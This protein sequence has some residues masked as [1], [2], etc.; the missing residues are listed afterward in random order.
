MPIT[1]ILAIKMDI[2]IKI[3]GKFSK[4]GME[5]NTFV[6]GINII[7]MKRKKI[8]MEMTNIG[9]EFNKIGVELIKSFR[10]ISKLC[11]F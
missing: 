5:S 6:M 10:L 8:R 1:D 9:M 2:N 4:I 11:P 3:L 7:G